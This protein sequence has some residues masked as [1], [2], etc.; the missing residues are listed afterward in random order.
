MT[1]AKIKYMR[2][3]SFRATIYAFVFIFFLSSSVLADR[4]DDLV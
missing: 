2:A 4:V 3:F 1:F